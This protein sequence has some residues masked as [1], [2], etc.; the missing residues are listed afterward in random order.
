M[1]KVLWVVTHEEDIA[2]NKIKALMLTRA[3]C[4]VS[5]HKSLM[6]PGEHVYMLGNI[7]REIKGK[8]NVQDSEAVL[9]G[10]LDVCQSKIR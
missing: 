4:Y 1:L 7:L 5:R 6:L 10:T 9:T 2:A 8:M 3:S